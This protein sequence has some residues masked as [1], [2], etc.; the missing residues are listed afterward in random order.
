MTRARWTPEEDQFMI[1]NYRKIGVVETADRLGRT[2]A[3]VHNRACILKI[4]ESVTPW[5][6]DEYEFFKNNYYKK[7]MYRLSKEMGRS[8]KGIQTQAKRLGYRPLTLDDRK[9]LRDMF[10]N[11]YTAQEIASAMHMTLEAM[12][13]WADSEGKTIEE[14]ELEG[15]KNND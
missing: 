4:T 3:S 15:A 2:T 11:G 9:G 5:T 13:S 12:E 10:D 7:T 8:R 6:E 14:L 1:D